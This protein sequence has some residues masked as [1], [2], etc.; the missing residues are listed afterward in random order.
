MQSFSR[1][2]LFSS[3]QD[4]IY[5]CTETVGKKYPI[6]IE[7]VPSITRLATSSLVIIDSEFFTEHEIFFSNLQKNILSKIIFLILSTS[8]K[9]DLKIIEKKNFVYL[10]FSSRTKIFF[11]TYR[12]YFI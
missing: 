11:Y 7:E 4:V 1:I 10:C 12:K 5:F 9:I 2:T 6:M 8:K 3:H